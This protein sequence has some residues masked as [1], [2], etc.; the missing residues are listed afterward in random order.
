MRSCLEDIKEVKGEIAED[1]EEEGEDLREGEREIE[2]RIEL[3]TNRPVRITG[4]QTRL[5]GILVERKI[6]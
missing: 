6:E 1:K 3:S 5:L 4:P 2:G